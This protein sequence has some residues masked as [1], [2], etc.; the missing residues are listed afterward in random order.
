M[1]RKRLSKSS[2]L[3]F[4]RSR[5]YVTLADV[6]RRFGVEL[7]EDVSGIRGPQGLAFVGLP[8]QQARIVQELWCEGKIGLEFAHDIMAPSVNGVYGIFGPGGSYPHA[9]PA[10]V[11][12]DYDREVETEELG[13]AATA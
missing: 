13:E 2:L 3:W 4:I 11:G 7:G 9:A 5:S 1:A 6:R 12:I 8:T 10:C